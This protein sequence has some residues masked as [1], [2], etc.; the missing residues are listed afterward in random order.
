MAGPRAPGT[1]FPPLFTF[2]TIL[3]S[4][5]LQLIYLLGQQQQLGQRRWTRETMARAPDTRHRRVLCP[6]YVLIL[7]TFLTV[8]TSFILQL[9]YLLQ[10]LQPVEV[11]IRQGLETGPCLKP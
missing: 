7:F 5:F 9:N 6:R 4:F 11:G 1:R 3:M 8:P 10:Q 2:L